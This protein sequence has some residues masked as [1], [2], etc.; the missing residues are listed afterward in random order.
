MSIESKIEEIIE[1]Y[2]DRHG[3]E[4][5]SYCNEQI[6][7]ELS[8]L[9]QKEREQGIKDFAKWIAD[10]DMPEAFEEWVEE[11]LNQY[12]VTKRDKE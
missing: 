10:D 3:A 12:Q 7:K 8:T 6:A 11:F 5:S 2:Y 9:I 1:N 4:Y